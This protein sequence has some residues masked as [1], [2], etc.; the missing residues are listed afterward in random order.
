[1]TPSQKLTELLLV[2][3][4]SESEILVYQEL[5]RMPVTFVYQLVGRTGLSKSV[6]YRTIE[7]LRKHGMIREDGQGV[8]AAS[9]KSLVASLDQRS[10]RLL[11]AASGLRKISPFLRV[12]LE[13]VEEYQH[14]YGEDQVADAYLSMAQRVG[15]S[16]GSVNLDFGDFE[17]FLPKIGGH[18]VG[19]RFR[20]ERAKRATNKAICTTFGPTSAYYCTKRDEIEFRNVVRVLDLDFKDRFMVFSDTGDYVLFANTA[21]EDVDAVL[22]KSRIIADMQRSQFAAF[23]QKFGNF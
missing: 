5:L 3:G 9:L 7:A 22:V 6:V 20:E 8:H 14:F 16:D 4:L 19:N 2:I 21:G 17:S 11:K 12:P 23:S 13:A 10:R 18:D 15:D 1:M